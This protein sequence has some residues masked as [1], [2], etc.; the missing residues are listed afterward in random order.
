MT[1]IF[2]VAIYSIWIQWD[3]A[4]E[5]TT[6]QQ[7]SSSHSRMVYTTHCHILWWTNIA[8]ENGHL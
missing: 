8:M 5:E 3:D 6:N 1:E 7:C 2:G 4:V